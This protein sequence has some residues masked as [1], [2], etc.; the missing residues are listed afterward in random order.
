MMTQKRPQGKPDGGATQAITVLMD[1]PSGTPTVYLVVPFRPGLQIVTSKSARGGWHL[2]S[3]GVCD[4][5]YNR[6]RPG[7]ARRNP[8]THVRAIE[9]A[10]EQAERAVVWALAAP[11]TGDRWTLELRPVE[12]PHAGH[13][14]ILHRNWRY[15]EA[16]AYGEAAACSCRAYYEVSFS[17]AT[18]G[19]ASLASERYGVS[20]EP[21]AAPVRTTGREIL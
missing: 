8:C 5:T 2:V 21:G 1:A 4:C 19:D 13:T 12:G 14:M 6:L 11:P 9:Q 18:D 17:G 3:E 20:R 15:G 7:M 10:A 16:P